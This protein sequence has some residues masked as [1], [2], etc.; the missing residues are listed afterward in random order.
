MQVC[1]VGLLLLKLIE[2]TLIV[3]NGRGKIPTLS[4]LDKN[5]S[6]DVCLF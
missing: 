6:I 1:N 4:F 3:T 2:P 5:K